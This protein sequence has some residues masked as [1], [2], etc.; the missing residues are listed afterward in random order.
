MET[1]R[2]LISHPSTHQM[3]PHRPGRGRP[4]LSERC[5][6]VGQ[7]LYIWLFFFPLRWNSVRWAKTNA[8]TS[9]FSRISGKLTSPKSWCYELQLETEP[10]SWLPPHVGMLFWPV[11]GAESVNSPG[12]PHLCSY[13]PFSTW[14]R[15]QG[16]A[17]RQKQPLSSL[18]I[19]CKEGWALS[20]LT[21]DGSHPEGCRA[22]PSM[23]ISFK[24]SDRSLEDFFTTWGFP[25]SV[26]ASVVFVL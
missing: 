12:G 19:P 11:A 9:S 10:I 21:F 8:L 15:A 24:L 2:S 1:M 13:S 3:C 5:S 25:R 16:L 6:Q 4:F 22:S 23:W 14:P 20:R 7:N 26:C 17:R 18:R